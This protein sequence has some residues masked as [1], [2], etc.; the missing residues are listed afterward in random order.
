M[1]VSLQFTLHNL[2]FGMR[3]IFF[4]FRPITLNTWH[5]VKISRKDTEGQLQVR[6]QE[7]ATDRIDEQ[8]QVKGRIP[9]DSYRYDTKK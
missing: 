2:N 4:Y 9:S 6:Y 1:Y 3:N 8:L 5:K 7:I